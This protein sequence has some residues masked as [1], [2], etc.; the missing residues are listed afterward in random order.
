MNITF[1][2]FGA[3][4]FALTAIFNYHSARK[5]E[6]S[7]LPAIMGVMMCISI[8]LFLVSRE[9]G[10]IAFLLTMIFGIANYNKAK[11]INENKMKR[12]MVDS[13]NADSLKLNDYFSGWKLLHLLHRKYGPGKASLINSFVMW[14]FGVL[15]VKMYIYLWPEIFT[16][17]WS[18]ILVITTITA[19]FYRQNKKLLENLDGDA[20]QQNKKEVF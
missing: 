3:V 6:G 10:S 14:V 9:A 16:N 5:Y 8:F 7:Y 17:F 11:T 4:F 18:L 13:K 2:H 15:M 19:L 1:F 12:Y 20:F